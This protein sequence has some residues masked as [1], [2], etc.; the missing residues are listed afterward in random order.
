[1]EDEYEELTS[2]EPD[3]LIN[4]EKAPIE[5]QILWAIKTL[6]NNLVAYFRQEK[7]KT[8]SKTKSKEK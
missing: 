3:L 1:M 6:N 5:Q 8:K 4:S 2:N 7:T